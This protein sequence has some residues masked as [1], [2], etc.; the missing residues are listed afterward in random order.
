MMPTTTVLF[1]LPAIN[2]PVLLLHKTMALLNTGQKE[3][4]ARTVSILANVFAALKMVVLL[5]VR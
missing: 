3:K 1:V 5:A 2:S 4:L